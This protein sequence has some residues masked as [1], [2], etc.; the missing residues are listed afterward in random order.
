MHLHSQ[1]RYYS[2]KRSDCGHGFSVFYFGNIRL[3][4]A[5]PLSKLSLRNPCLSAGIPK[6]LCIVFFPGMGFLCLPCFG[7]HWTEPLNEMSGY[8][9]ILWIAFLLH[10]RWFLAKV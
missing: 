7:P 3:I 8:V 5:Y 2:I 6:D 9:I 4:R 1:C 10:R